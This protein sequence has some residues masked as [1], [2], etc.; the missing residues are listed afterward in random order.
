MRKSWGLLE[1]IRNGEKTIESRWYLS[2]RAPWNNIEKGDVVYFKNSGEPVSLMTKVS[3]VLQFAELTPKKVREI[4]DKYG[5]K[6]GLDIGQ[7]DYFFDLF[8]EKKYCL[9]VFL[10]QP[11]NISPFEI[12]KKGFG[13]MSAWMVFDKL[14]RIKKIKQSF[15]QKTLIK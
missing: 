12:D 1:K 11:E 3:K 10:E 4:L 15:K 14:E 8:K 6:D 9:L 2:K 5:Q 13:S 7:L